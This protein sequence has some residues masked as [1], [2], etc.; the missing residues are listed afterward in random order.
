MSEFKVTSVGIETDFF[1]FVGILVAFRGF[2]MLDKFGRSP[3][4]TLFLLIRSSS[5]VAS[6][7]AFLLVAA[8]VILTQFS[9]SSAMIV[10]IQERD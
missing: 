4:T 10:L 8:L 3:R 9:F 6:I 7:E 2:L 1:C 5:I